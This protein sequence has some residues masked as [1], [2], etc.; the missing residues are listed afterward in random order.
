M[1]R[2]PLVV[3]L[4]VATLVGSGLTGGV[5]AAAMDAAGTSGNMQEAPQP[6]SRKHGDFMAKWAKALDLTA[7]QQTQIKAL[8]Q[9]ERQTTASLRSQL[10]DG[11]KNL[12]Q[13]LKPGALN[14]AAARSLLAS[15]ASLRT[16]MIIAHAKL[17]NQ[18]FALLTPDQ[19]KLAEKLR[20]LMGPGGGHRSHGAW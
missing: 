13:A 3:A 6:P 20:D 17:E 9:A 12:Q 14:E 1:K 15:Q 2:K 18:I 5:F 10:A 7:D 11:H 16:E 4:T 8:V 19:Q